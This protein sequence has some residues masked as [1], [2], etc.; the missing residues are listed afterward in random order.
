MALVAQPL[1]LSRHRS[2]HHHRITGLEGKDLGIDYTRLQARGMEEK[3]V[4][5]RACRG[6][7]TD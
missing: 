6:I 7:Q 5:W 4:E 3:E 2:D 1:I